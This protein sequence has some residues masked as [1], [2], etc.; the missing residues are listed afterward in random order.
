MLN[1]LIVGVDLPFDEK[2]FVSGFS[3]LMPL[4]G[5]EKLTLAHVKTLDEPAAEKAQQELRGYAQ[6]L[7]EKLNL[8]QVNFTVEPGLPADQL[9]QIASKNRA[10]GVV[11]L[12]NNH[13]KTYEFFLGSVALNIARTTYFPLLLLTEQPEEP[14]GTL[15]LASDGSLAAS[16]AER[17]FSRLGERAQHSVIIN[18]QTDHDRTAHE[19]A[20]QDL[21]AKYEKDEK[22]EVI[23]AQGDPIKEILQSSR[24][25]AIDLLVLGKRGQNP[26]KQLMF[27]S[28]A[29]RLCRQLK[30][31]VLIIPPNL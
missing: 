16:A 20:I 21:Q 10:D 9:N 14:T 3:A 27:G 26:L 31:P 29:E 4:L 15:M 13:S 28:T 12:F 22:V 6:L 11:I 17:F 19:R 8:K 5:V 30:R 24:Y 25:H 1:H 18:V 7:Q 2:R 23:R